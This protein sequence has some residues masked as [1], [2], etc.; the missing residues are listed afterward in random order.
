MAAYKQAILYILAFIGYAIIATIIMGVGFTMGAADLLTGN[1]G[2]AGILGILIFIIGVIFYILA[3]FA[4][5]IYAASRGKKKAVGFFEAYKVT[6]QLVLELGVAV[7]V[8]IALFVVG[9]QV[10][11]ALSALMF[12]IGGFIF[13]LFP[14]AGLFYVIN[15]L[16]ARK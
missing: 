2:G 1:F 4:A 16:T 9:I 6:F 11:G 5:I 7:L 14:I 3:A 8:A 12:I 13:A 10:G 15:Y